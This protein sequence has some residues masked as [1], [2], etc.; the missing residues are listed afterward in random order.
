MGKQI[1]FLLDKDTEKRFIEF[2]MQDQEC[3]IRLRK[4]NGER[5]AIK[6]AS[7]LLE[8]DEFQ[9]HIYRKNFGNVEY[10]ILN[11]GRV[12]YNTTFTPEIVYSR[13]ITRELPQKEIIRGRL[14]VE[15]RYYDD[16]GNIVMK[17]EKLDEC[18]KQLVKWIKRNAKRRTAVLTNGR[19]L[20]YYMTDS[21]QVLLEGGEYTFRG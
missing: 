8:S 10:E 14:W 4:K 13:T 7:E 15:M 5:Y 20:T 21:M 6:E 17:D 1:G 16:D 2:I 19:I 9:V 18:Y 12:F 3:D 11:N